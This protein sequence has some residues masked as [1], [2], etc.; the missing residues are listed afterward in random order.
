ML[1]IN[2]SAQGHH[3]RTEAERGDRPGMFLGN[4]VEKVHRRYV[5]RGEKQEQDEWDESSVFEC[6]GKIA[7]GRRARRR[8]TPTRRNVQPMTAIFPISSRTY[9]GPCDHRNGQVQLN[10]LQ[11]DRTTGL[12]VGFGLDNALWKVQRS[13][14]TIAVKRFSLVPCRWPQPDWSV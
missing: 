7:R 2:V 14:L 3:H 10:R 13:F 4:C 9:A 8:L 11:K 1:G 6:P 5:V 12:H